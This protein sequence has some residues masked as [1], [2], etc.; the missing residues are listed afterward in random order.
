MSHLNARC[1]AGVLQIGFTVLVFVVLPWWLAV[2]IAYF[3]WHPAVT[4]TRTVQALCSE[5]MVCRG[6]H[7]QRS[8][9]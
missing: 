1:V 2:P 4:T 5:C 6:E 9:S 8:R 7:R 3:S